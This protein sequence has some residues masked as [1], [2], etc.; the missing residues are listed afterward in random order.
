MAE[1]LT[2][3]PDLHWLAL[4]R[5]LL[6]CGPVPSVDQATGNLPVLRQASVS[7]DE[8]VLV[9]GYRQ[10]LSGAAGP[11]ASGGR[12]AVLRATQAARLQDGDGHA[13]HQITAVP[14]NQVLVRNE[15]RGQG[16][17]GQGAATPRT[18]ALVATVDGPRWLAD[19]GTLAGWDRHSLRSGIV[20]ARDWLQAQ[21]QAL[22][23]VS[24]E[25]DAFTVSGTTVHNVIA[26][27][28]GS[29]RPEQIIVVGG[30]YDA[31]GGSFSPGG[32]DNASGCA[33]VLEIARVFAADPPPVTLRLVCYAG[34]EQGLRGS[35]HQVADLQNAGET[36]QVL[37]MLNMDM[38]GYSG[39]ADLDCLLETNP[40]YADLLDVYADAAA[41]Y[42]TLRI[43]TSLNAF[44]SD[45]VPFLNAGMP[46]LLTIENDW[47]SYPDYHR[48]TDVAANVDLQMGF[49]TLRMNVA[50]LAGLMGLDEP[51]VF[52]DGFED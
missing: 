28:P 21:F 26:T 3:A 13:H 9:R 17:S 29:S 37:S 52:A 36:G 38:I 33:G 24:V 41:R 50:A 20:S 30:H 1:P 48:S 10:S 42:T 11:L 39:D 4:D 31:I 23:G 44:G 6:L 35:Q 15:G 14:W 32:E 46:A 45:H 43:V 51:A 27:L 8:L 25:L 7:P 19:V 5:E 16:K 18:D 12:L 40:P 47:D 22:P 34:E 2:R 49:Q